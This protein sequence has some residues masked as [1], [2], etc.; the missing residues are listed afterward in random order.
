MILQPPLNSAAN[1]YHVLDV[2]HARKVSAE[3]VL[4]EYL[5][6]RIIDPWEKRKVLE[7]IQEIHNKV[8]NVEKVI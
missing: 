4:S 7:E 8:K 5:N 3:T 1:P 2:A 6:E